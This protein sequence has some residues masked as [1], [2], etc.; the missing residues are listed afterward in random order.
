MSG[1][2]FGGDEIKRKKYKIEHPRGNK[3]GGGIS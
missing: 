1:K 3:R 2:K